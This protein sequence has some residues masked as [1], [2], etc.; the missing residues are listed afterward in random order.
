KVGWC[1]RATRSARTVALGIAV[2]PV[3]VG[4]VTPVRATIAT[5]APVA[6]FTV[7]RPDD[8]GPGSLRQAILDANAHPGYDLIAFAIGS[9]PHAIYPLALLPSITDPAILDATT[10]PG[11]AGMPLIEINGSRAG[12]A[13][14]IT[15]TAGGTTV[16]GLVIDAFDGNGLLLA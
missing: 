12:G 15:V 13:T 5:D 6:T 3:M 2:V 16:R 14:G 8:S 11:Y 7:T 4:W 9:W 10:Q 1:T